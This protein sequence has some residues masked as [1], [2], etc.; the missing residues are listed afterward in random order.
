VYLLG[1]NTQIGVNHNVYMLNLEN[2]KKPVWHL[3]KVENVPSLDG[4][5]AVSVASN[6][7]VFGGF[8]NS[9]KSNSLYVLD[10][11]NRSWSQISGDDVLDNIIPEARSDH[12]CVITSCGT[13]MIIF[14]GVTSLNDRLND[15]WIYNF[16]EHRWAQIVIDQPDAPRARSGHTANI[17]NDKYMLVFGGTYSIKNEMNDLHVLD[18]ESQRWVFLYKNIAHEIKKTPKKYFPGGTSRS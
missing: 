6:I 7:Y 13:K 1:G 3:L 18:I 8:V 5:T 4:H 2:I 9:I 17:Y 16:Q 15:T 11:I 12:S 14:G 10:T